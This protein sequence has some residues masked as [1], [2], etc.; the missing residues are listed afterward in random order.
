MAAAQSLEECSRKMGYSRGN[1]NMSRQEERNT[2]KTYSGP[3]S[4]GAGS[5][6]RNGGVISIMHTKV[7][8]PDTP[9]TLLYSSQLHTKGHH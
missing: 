2:E 5:I 6:C 1:C 7:T 9:N 4:R 8:Y 3:V